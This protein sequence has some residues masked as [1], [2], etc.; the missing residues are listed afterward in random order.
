MV[1]CDKPGNLPQALR[2]KLSSIL[3]AAFAVGPLARLTVTGPTAP[4]SMGAKVTVTA[5]ATD[6]NGAAIAGVPVT[7]AVDGATVLSF[8]ATTDAN[9]QA[10][11]SWTRSKMIDDL[12]TA[13]AA[14]QLATITSPVFT[15]GWANPIARGRPRRAMIRCKA[16]KQCRSPRPVSRWR[17]W[18]TQSMA[19]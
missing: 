2:S 17:E 16:P 1:Q 13:T 14:S 3:A 4:V 10:R 7:F 11:A 9:G 12:V 5:T 8:G 18:C 6:A 15:V 19:W